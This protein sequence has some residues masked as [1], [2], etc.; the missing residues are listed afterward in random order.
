[1][2]D[3][4]LKIHL[5]GGLL[6]ASYLLIFGISSLNYNHHFGQDADDKVQWERILEVVD[7]KEKM[8]VAKKVRD[9]LGLIGWTIPWETRRDDAGNLHFGLARPGKHYTIHVF[10]KEGRV[11]VDEDRKGFWQVINQLHALTGIP[12]SPFVD[13]WGIF[14]EICVWVVLFSACS[15]VYL[16]ATLKRDRL[17]GTL[18]LFG[19]FA[20]SLC[21]MLYI[22]WRG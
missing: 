7:Q 9:D 22:W 11:A 14:T 4:I 8:A 13:T 10:F 6:C 1:M 2:R 20:F 15:G 12:N 21:F 18:L 19:S 3:A 5:Y 16:W 17:V